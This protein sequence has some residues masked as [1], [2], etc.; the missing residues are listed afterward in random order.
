MKSDYFD[1]DQLGVSHHLKKFK[2][3]IL[4]YVEQNHSLINCRLQQLKVR[5]LFLFLFNKIYPLD[6]RYIMHVILMIFFNC[7]KG[8]LPENTLPEKGVAGKGHCRKRFA[9]KGFAGKE[10]A[11][12]ALPEKGFPHENHF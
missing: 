11:G 6:S 1:C 10:F 4:I 8:S 3:V 12:N 9:G 2:S 7:R 5:K